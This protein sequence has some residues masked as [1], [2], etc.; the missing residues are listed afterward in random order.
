MKILV[1]PTSFNKDSCRAAKATLEQFL[2]PD[3]EIIFNP[4]GRP[5]TGDEVI[6]L[7]DGIDG[8]IAGLDE[9]STEV[10]LNAPYSLKVI[11]RY[12]AGYDRVDIEAAG[13]RGIVVTN[14]P[15][16]NSESVADLALCL[17]LSV[18]RKV[19]FLDREVRKGNWPRTI[20]TEIYKKKLGI[21]GLGAI[22]KGVALRAKGFSM[23]ILAYDP[24]IDKSFVRANG[25]KECTFDELIYNSDYISLHLPLNKQTK[26]II[27][28]SVIEK[29]K[30]GVIIVNTARGG[31]IDEKAAYEALREGKLGGLGLD[32]FSEEPPGDSPLF[33]LD[34]VVAT[35]HAGA[36]T[37]EAVANMGILAVQNLIDVLSGKKCRYITNKRYLS[38]NYNKYE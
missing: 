5:L 6:T 29:M 17:M 33:R 30:P 7:L 36:H 19:T 10:I 20:G 35:P 11:S 37:R 14:T 16:V 2:E 38:I 13:K 24:Y 27:N 1:T 23:E 26:N 21:L 3:G 8:Y 18:S 34:N 9:I 22:G 28:A 15:G 25:I 31:L 4:Y 32:A 12:G